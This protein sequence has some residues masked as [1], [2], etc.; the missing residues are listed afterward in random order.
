MP[1]IAGCVPLQ[2]LRYVTLTVPDETKPPIV[3]S[4]KAGFRLLSSAT[5]R[6]IAKFIAKVLSATQR[7]R[8]AVQ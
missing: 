8:Y 6:Q 5:N 3:E 4:G 7:I 1:V 2:E